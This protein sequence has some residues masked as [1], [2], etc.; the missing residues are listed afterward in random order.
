MKDLKAI[1]KEF[2]LIH[3]SLFLITGTIEYINLA[4]AFISLSKLVHDYEGESDD[5][6]YIG[7]HSMC[8]LDNLI[9]GAYWHYSDWHDGK[10]GYAALS[11]LGTIFN[12]NMAGAEEDNEAYQALN[13]MAE[14]ATTN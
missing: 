8:S 6:W 10:V 1:K 4:A 2:Q 5:I 11:A 13:T 7:E 3:D 9:V 12:P 14:E